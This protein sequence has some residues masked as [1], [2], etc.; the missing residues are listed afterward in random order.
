MRAKQC[1]TASD[2]QK[3]VKASKDFAQAS[4]WSVSIAVVDDGGF[5]LHL[6]RLDGAVLQS[7]E[8]AILKARTAAICRCPTKTLEEVA[9]ER[10]ATLT[11]PG[12]LPIQ[13]GL[14]INVMGECIGGIGISGV[15]S[16][17]DERVAEAGLAALELQ[18]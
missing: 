15:K 11:F 7:P 6:E 9:K 10:P 18:V 14:P 17:E 13:G 2:A 5:L 16:H 3:M 12:R 8:L 4:G 1:L